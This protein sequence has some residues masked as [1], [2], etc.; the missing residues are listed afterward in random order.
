M[1][2]LLYVVYHDACL[3]LVYI[4][5]KAKAI[6]DDGGVALVLSTAAPCCWPCHKPCLSLVTLSLWVWHQDS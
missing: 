6:P 5:A 1:I 4:P 3:V 2:G